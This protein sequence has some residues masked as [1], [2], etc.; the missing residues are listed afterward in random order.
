MKPVNLFDEDGCEENV[1]KISKDEIVK[2]LSEKI[3]EQL[4]SDLRIEIKKGIEKAL[5]QRY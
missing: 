5:G 2:E 3:Y 1:F 4:K